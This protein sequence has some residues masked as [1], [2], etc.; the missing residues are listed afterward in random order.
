MGSRTILVV[1]G[2]R[3]EAEAIIRDS[4]VCIGELARR[5]D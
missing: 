4:D 2:S 3:K 5:E 1:S